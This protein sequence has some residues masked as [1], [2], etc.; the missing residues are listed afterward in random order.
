MD[1]Q[2]TKTYGTEAMGV[3]REI[4]CY[5]N[6][7]SSVEVIAP[8]GAELDPDAVGANEVTGG[9]IP[10]WAN[11]EEGTKINWTAT[12]FSDGEAKSDR[13]NVNLVVADLR[14][15]AR[16]S[17]QMFNNMT[18]AD[19]EELMEDPATKMEEF[20]QRVWDS[21]DM[22]LL[23][24][25]IW[26]DTLETNEKGEASGTIELPPQ[27][28]KGSY[29]LLIHYGYHAQ[30]EK[31]GGTLATSW[32]WW[33]DSKA[34]DFWLEEMGP[35]IV[36]LVIAIIA[37]IV[38]VGTGLFTAAASCLPAGAAWA[39]FA[40]EIAIDLSMMYV[41]FQQDMWGIVGLNQYDCDFPFEGFMHSYAFGFMTPEEEQAMADEVSP[42]N[43]EILV[44][45]DAFILEKGLVASVMGGALILGL[46][47]IFMAKLKGRGK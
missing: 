13:I 28:P 44:A 36:G 20:N 3:D 7:K 34:Q 18:E 16:I 45:A 42:V 17:N 43:Q 1:G 8:N 6:L 21:I 33:K 11:L 12:T 30:S 29:S 10:A 38:C 23:M 27:W 35:T 32:M 37:S 25:N 2:P 39:L 31:E 5:T 47:L 22:S 15:V 14:Y 40:V 9:N 46:L 4:E 19:L 26:T 41:H 24:K